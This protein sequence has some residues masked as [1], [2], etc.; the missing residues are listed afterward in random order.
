LVPLIFQLLLLIAPSPTAGMQP[1]NQAYRVDEVALPPWA[2]SPEDFIRKHREALE[3]PHVTE[4]LH[5]WIDL[6]FGYKQRGHGAR[7]SAE[8]Y[9]RGCHWIPRMFA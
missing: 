7:F 9:T 5:E 6:I 2:S 1:P 4:H 8:I 3:S